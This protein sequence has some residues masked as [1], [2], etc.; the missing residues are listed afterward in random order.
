MT[1][2]SV[3]SSSSVM[4]GGMKNMQR[5]DASKMAEDLFS[6][7]DTSGKGYIEKSDLASALSNISGSSSSSSSAADEMFTK[8]DSN[9]NG[10]VTQ[11]EVSATL[12]KIASQLDGPFP[13]MRLQEGQNSQGSQ[14]EL[15]PPP[16]PQEGNQ[17]PQSTSSTDSSSSSQSSDPAD[18]NGDGTVSA[19]EAFAYAEKQLLSANDSSSTT[20]ADAQMMQMLGGMPPPPK[21]GGLDDQGFTKDQLTSM[22]KEVSS[23]DSQRSQ[24]MSDIASNFDAADTN[25]DGKVSG[26]EA[27]AFEESKSSSSTDSSSNGSSTVA[28]NTSDAQ[29]M[30]QMMDLLHAYSGFDQPTESNRISTSA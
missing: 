26:S 12:E 9:G 30:K 6:K 25:G 16:P 23:T 18:T 3:N 13:R 1:I 8:L 27:R 29:F 21:N 24:I 11:E 20:N 28:S 7:L 14:G 22:S 15:P 10:K 5:P 19:K 4:L 17:N 2:S